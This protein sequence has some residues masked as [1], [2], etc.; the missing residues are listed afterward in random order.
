MYG[1]AGNR[2]LR[3]HVYVAVIEFGLEEREHDDLDLIYLSQDGKTWQAVVSTVMNIRILDN[4]WNFLNRCETV[5]LGR[6]ANLWRQTVKLDWTCGW[7]EEWLNGWFSGKVDI[8]L[9]LRKGNFTAFLSGR[10]Q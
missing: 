8:T 1:F 2:P 9:P 5:F 4:P 3:R 6:R 7:T 10:M